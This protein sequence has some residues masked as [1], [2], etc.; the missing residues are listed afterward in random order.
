MPSLVQKFEKGPLTFN[1]GPNTI[2]G[3]RLVMPDTGNPGNIIHTTLNTPNCLGVAL[4][5]AAPLSGQTVDGFAVSSAI[6]RPDV[7][8]ANEGVYRLW[9]SAAIPFGSYV[10]ADAN[11][12]VKAY[13]AGTSTYDQIVGKC[14]EPNGISA[15]ISGVNQRGKVLIDIV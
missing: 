5:D 2:T 6:I 8:V 14:V 9:A 13:T 12:Y 3:G 10:V 15:P 4:L 11:G 1:C 7:A